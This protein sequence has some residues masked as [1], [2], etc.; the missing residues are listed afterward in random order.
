M[1]SRFFSLLKALTWV[2]NNTSGREAAFFYHHITH[3]FLA[4]GAQGR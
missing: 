1:H 3:T 2:G 4:E